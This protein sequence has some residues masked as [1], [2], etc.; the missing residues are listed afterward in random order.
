[1]TRTELDALRAQYAAAVPDDHI[2]GAFFSKAHLR[3]LLNKHKDASGLFI[4]I[5]ANP[6]GESKFTMHAEAFDANRKPYPEKKSSKKN[7]I[8]R[9]LDDPGSLSAYPCPPRSGCP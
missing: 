5:I 9:D 3:A 8:T 7:T 4:Y 2:K 6:T 1:M